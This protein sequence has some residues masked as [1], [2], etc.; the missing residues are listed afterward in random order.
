MS[1]PD[2]PLPW[3][4]LWQ[5]KFIEWVQSFHSAN[6]D[7]VAGSLTSLGIESFYILALPILFWS[8]HKRIGLRITYIFLT[9]MFMNAWL[10]NVFH[11]VRPIGVPGIQSGYLWSA[12]SYSMPSSHAQGPMM[13][14]TM[15]AKWVQR[16]WVYVFG[17]V[18]V[19][20]IGL[21][22]VYLGLH[23]PMDV[24]VGW[25]IGLVVGLVGWQLGK[26]WTYRNYAFQVRLFAAIAVPVTL[27]IL[28]T[29][30]QAHQFAAYL[31]GI[32]V[33]AVVEGQWLN[34][35]L[36]ALVWKR[37]CAA[38]I[39]IGGVIALQYAVKW[40]SEANGW[41]IVRNIC[42]GLWATLFAPSVFLQCGLYRRGERDDIA[43]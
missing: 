11:I 25:A 1:N 36:D 30:A 42:I 14:W 29:S 3:G 18:L 7:R 43:T 16:K 21:S 2:F 27:A 12:T 22:R 35:E 13:F 5:Y 26:W 4:Y 15:V 32:G 28:H 39:G 40:P 10:K 34:T 24:I 19:A 9:G 8:V 38:L 31:F 41:P 23:W 37:I 20:L 6:L 33:G 17:I